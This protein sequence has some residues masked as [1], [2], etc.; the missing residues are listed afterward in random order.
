MILE[1]SVSATCPFAGASGDCALRGDL[2]CPEGELVGVELLHLLADRGNVVD[3]AQVLER[4]KLG[5]WRRVDTQAGKGKHP[6]AAPLVDGSLDFRRPHEVGLVWR[7]SPVLGNGNIIVRAPDL[8]LG[9]VP[10]ATRVST[11]EPAG[12]VRPCSFIPLREVLITPN[13]AALA[14]MG[15]QDNATFDEV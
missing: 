14:V 3:Q 1:N 9:T 8:V 2:P 7:P 13:M 12:F 6:S 10:A 5:S 15:C 4:E 11:D